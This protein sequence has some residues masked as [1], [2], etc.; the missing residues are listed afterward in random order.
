MGCQQSNIKIDTPSPKHEVFATLKLKKSRALAKTEK[1]IIKSSI[2]IFKPIYVSRGSIS[3]SSSTSKATLSPILYNDR[4]L[5]RRKVEKM[6]SR[7]LLMKNQSFSIAV[8][9]KT[10][11]S[12]PNHNGKLL[13]SKSHFF[14]FSKNNN[15][16]NTQSD[17]KIEKK[18]TKN[19]NQLNSE[20]LQKHKICYNLLPKLNK[21]NK[22]SKTIS[23]SSVLDYN[24]LPSIFKPI[25]LKTFNTSQ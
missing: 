15:I 12:L 21:K 2:Q 6:R 24:R 25:G 20:K 14:K 22:T 1:R 13:K 17:P 23:S 8:E 5:L 19:H 9:Q 7:P 4:D 3:T 11:K 18:E 10:A 16:E